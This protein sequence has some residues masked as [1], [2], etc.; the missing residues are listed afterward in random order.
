MLTQAQRAGEIDRRSLMPLLGGSA[1]F[2]MLE[3][4]A[5]AQQYPIPTTATEVPGPPT[6]TTMTK[7]YVQSVG[8]AAYLWGWPLTEGS[9]RWSPVHH[10]LRLSASR[11]VRAA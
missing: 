10:P 6:G 8:R 5:Q 4:K 7:A 3:G 9:Q 11:S 2:L 1:A